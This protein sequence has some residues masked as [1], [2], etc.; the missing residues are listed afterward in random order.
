MLADSRPSDETTQTNRV[1]TK[2]EN[3]P[4]RRRLPFVRVRVRPTPCGLAPTDFA[5][6]STRSLL[7]GWLLSSLLLIWCRRNPRTSPS[8][9]SRLSIPYIGGS[10]NTSIVIGIVIR[11]ISSLSA[12]PRCSLFAPQSHSVVPASHL[13]FSPLPIGR[14]RALGRQASPNRQGISSRHRLWP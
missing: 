2:A 4:R 9:V 7:C 10:I 1:A 12:G 3:P 5:A 14:L 6:F 13:L 11:S 8:A